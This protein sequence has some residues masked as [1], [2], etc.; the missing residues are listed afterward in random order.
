MKILH[1]VSKDLDATE[2]KIVDEQSKSNETTVFDVR[3]DKDYDRLVD[4]I[5][6]A[7]KVISW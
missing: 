3:A 5:D 4:L 6:S 7:D 2:Q 1:V